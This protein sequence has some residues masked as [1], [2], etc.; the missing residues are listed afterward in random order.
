M[1]QVAAHVNLTVQYHRLPLN[2]SLFV[3]VVLPLCPL[4]LPLTRL[5]APLRPVSFHLR[6]RRL[7]WPWLP[8][9]HPLRCSQRPW[10]PPKPVFGYYNC[11]RFFLS[12]CCPA[13]GRGS[14][15][16]H[17]A[18]RATIR[19]AYHVPLRLTGRRANP[20]I[21][22]GNKLPGWSPLSSRLSRRCAGQ[23]TRTPRLRQRPSA[24]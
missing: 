6:F 20:F 24:A 5:S 13:G 22:R 9:S 17:S 2:L 10:P 8:A 15:C 21:A 14:R 16:S 3:V 11:R 12:R 7:F 23:R 4:Q 19:P 1:L 18:P